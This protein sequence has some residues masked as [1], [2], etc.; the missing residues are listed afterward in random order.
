MKSALGSPKFLMVLS[1]LALAQ[2]ACNLGAQPAGEPTAQPLAQ[3]TAQPAIASP[4]PTPSNE[5][6]ATATTPPS[7]ATLSEHGTPEE[8]QAML[9]KAIEHYNL[10]GRDQARADFNNRV[11]PFFDRDLYV[12]CIDTHLVISANGGFPNVV[13]TPGGPLTRSTWDAASTTSIGSVNYSYL[14]PVTKQAEPKTFYYEKVGSDVCGV[15]AY[16]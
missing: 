4:Q 14:N 15:G 9:Q 10:V 2:F 1:V 8:A 11:A 12:A 5:P 6:Q 3:P 13:A 7:S 16:H